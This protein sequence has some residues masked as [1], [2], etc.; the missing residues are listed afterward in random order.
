MMYFKF[1]IGFGKGKKLQ[2]NGS[3]GC[4]TSGWDFV[5][6][7]VERLRTDG[8]Y[9]TA[10][11]Y[12]TAA[13]SWTR[14]LGNGNWSF[15][16]MSAER[17]EQYQRWLAGRGICLNTISAYM[18]SLRAMHRRAMEALAADGGPG[19][20]QTV[21]GSRSPFGKVF[22]G[23]AKTAK[24]SISEEEIRQLCALSLPKGSPLSFAR[25]LFMFSFYAMGMPFVDIAHLKKSQMKGGVI[26]YA[27][28]KTGHP[29]T[30]AILPPMLQIAERYAVSD[31]EYVFP[32]LSAQEGEALYK[33]YRH[34]LRQYNDA[35]HQLSEMIGAPQPLSS[36]VARH[37]W[38]SLA[39]QHHVDLAL[40]GKALG[41]TKSSTTLLYIKSLFD[42]DLADA[43]RSLMQCLEL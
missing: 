27:R 26:R 5:N 8:H 30:V 17:V 31:S 10:S 18:R 37:S 20:P 14:F 9:K 43:N 21:E 3:S 35:L 40:I 4:E 12:L 25:D 7:E 29:I 32:I 13:R 6:G 33:Q 41:H 2:G 11:N 42:R 38:A 23:R 1:E 22:T 28:H 34:S 36:Y 24:R 16:G 39:F 15:S 19:L